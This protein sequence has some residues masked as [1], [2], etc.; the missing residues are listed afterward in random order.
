MLC[1]VERINPY[2]I[3]K[4]IKESLK[5]YV[6]LLGFEEYVETQNLAIIECDGHQIHL[7]E[8]ENDPTKN[9]IWI[10]VE[11]IEM[12]YDQYKNYDVKFI[13]EPIN[14]SWAYQMII[15]DLDGNK[16]IFGSAPKP[17]QPFEDAID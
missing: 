6:N 7:L 4:D 17:G 9:R 15:Q 1:R 13:Q 8:S 10:G 2:L 16:L 12:L 11:D 3:V 14:F 5:F